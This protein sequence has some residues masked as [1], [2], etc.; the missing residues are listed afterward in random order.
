[1]MSFPMQIRFC[2][3]KLSFDSRTQVPSIFVLK[4]ISTC[5]PCGR[6]T[7]LTD[8]MDTEEFCI[9]INSSFASYDFYLDCLHGLLLM[10]TVSLLSR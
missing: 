5:V 4:R 10:E 1:M 8:T 7:S 6:T 2:M 9:D 3:Y